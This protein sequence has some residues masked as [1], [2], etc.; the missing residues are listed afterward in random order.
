[1]FEYR[2]EKEK[3]KERKQPKPLAQPSSSCTSFYASATL[4]P[5]LDSVVIK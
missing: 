3:K 5:I 4:E 2:K 1:M